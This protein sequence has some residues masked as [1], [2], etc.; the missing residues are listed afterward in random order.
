MRELQNICQS[1]CF[2]T[3]GVQYVLAYGIAI[4]WPHCLNVRHEFQR[5]LYASAYK[6]LCVNAFSYKKGGIFVVDIILSND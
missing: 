4:C 3:I 6:S 2:D 1:L 5:C